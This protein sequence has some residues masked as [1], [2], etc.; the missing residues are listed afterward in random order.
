LLQ[1]YSPHVPFC[2]GAATVRTAVVVL[3]LGRNQLDAVDVPETSGEHQEVIIRELE[4]A[5]G[6]RL[7]LTGCAR[8]WPVQNS[9]AS[10]SVGHSIKGRARDDAVRFIQTIWAGGK[11]EVR[12]RPAPRA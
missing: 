1:A 8:P 3:Y 9:G 5:A 2:F 11:L 6:V 7:D 4:A 10:I 12:Q